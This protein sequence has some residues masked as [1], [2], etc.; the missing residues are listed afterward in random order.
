MVYRAGTIM[1]NMRWP[2][3]CRHSPFNCGAVGPSR[4]SDVFSTN[5]TRQ[6]L[7][8]NWSLLCSLKTLAKPSIHP[9]LLHTHISTQIISPLFYTPLIWVLFQPNRCSSTAFSMNTAWKPHNNKDGLL[10]HTFLPSQ[11]LWSP[12]NNIYNIKIPP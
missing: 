12:F 7:R 3:L 1:N 6:S 8:T 2:V 10:S 5:L 4:E 11:T 9:L